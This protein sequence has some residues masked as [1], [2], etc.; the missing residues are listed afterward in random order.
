ME[1]TFFI[2]KRKFGEAPLSKSYEGQ[3]NE[4][5]YKVVCQNLVVV[6]SAIH[7]LVLAVPQFSQGGSLQLV[8]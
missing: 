8:G 4:V 1:S 6:T 7:E 5:L 3:V 2:I